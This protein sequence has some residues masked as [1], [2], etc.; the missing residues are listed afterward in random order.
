MLN[1]LYV[2]TVLYSVQYG[3]VRETRSVGT[4]GC[5]QSRGVPAR[6][7]GSRYSGESVCEGPV[8][9]ERVRGSGVLVQLFEHPA[10]EPQRVAPNL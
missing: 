8:R 4:C 10:R 5:A 9:R 6:G 3:S 1:Q 7:G 2:S